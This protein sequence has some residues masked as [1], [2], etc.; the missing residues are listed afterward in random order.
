MQE[1]DVPGGFSATA[2][3]EGV[4]RSARH[5][6]VAV[7]WAVVVTG[8][9]QFMAALDNL[10][11][12]MALPV[13]RE[14]L[15][16][17]LAG[18]QWTVN[19]YTLSFAVLLLTGAALGDRF[20]R[21]RMFVVGLVLFTLSSAAAALA[22]NIG[23][24]IAARALQGAGGALLV[25][26][27][28]T[29]LGAAVT[30]E[31]RN[32]ALGL[33]GALGGLTVA[34]GPLVGGAVVQGMSW[35]WIFWINVPLG[36]VLA[37]LARTRLRESHGPS[38]PLDLPGLVSASLGSL[39]I[40]FGLV[41][42]NQLGWG[43]AQV[44]ASFAGGALLLAAFFA[45]ERRTS[46]PM[47]P[48]RLFSHRGFTFVNVASLFMSFGMFGSIFLLAQFMQTVQ[49]LSPVSAGL[50]TL[51]WTGMPVLVAPLAAKLAERFGGR[52]LVAVGLA[53]QAGG[54]LWMAAIL[55]PT[56]PYGDVVPAFVLSGVGMALF[57]VPVAS[58]VLSSVANEEHGIASGVNNSVRELGGVLG[59]AVLGAVFAGSGGYASGA[60]F[61]AG[62][63]PAVAV[64]AAVV[65]LGFL[66]ALAIPRLRARRATSVA[67]CS[68]VAGAR[69]EIVLES[70]TP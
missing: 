22:P 23:T 11:V 32:A 1:V 24:L 67:P 46:A 28:L 25:P 64:G 7:G 3:G 6:G 55:R 19:A 50:R 52:I 60:S 2:T 57:F 5:A 49:H 39:G 41:R 14:K 48:L 10:V 29:L 8:T 38:R 13:I 53:L 30:P 15:H 54:L 42:A 68:A 31:R 18:L 45:R 34:I 33:W 9:A 61:V 51:P 47:L 16:A 44:V 36:L 43:S 56:L 69:P 4:S 63:V 37:P 66:A 59:I 58:L 17:G 21:R 26:L 40:V 65:S 70:A 20:G 62:L 35:Q 27:S 12:T